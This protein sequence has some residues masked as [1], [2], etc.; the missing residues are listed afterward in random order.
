MLCVA[1]NSWVTL[2][3]DMKN[4]FED[5]KSF[6]SPWAERK[7]QLRDFLA[8][9]GNLHSKCGAFNAR[10]QI[11]GNFSALKMLFHLWFP[12]YASYFHGGTAVSRQTLIFLSHF[13]I[14]LPERPVS[15]GQLGEFL[16]RLCSQGM[17]LGPK[18]CGDWEGYVDA[19]PWNSWWAT[20]PTRKRAWPEV[21]GSLYVKRG[22]PWKPGHLVKSHWKSLKKFA[23]G[24]FTIIS[25]PIL[26][27][28]YWGLLPWTRRVVVPAAPAMLSLQLL[29]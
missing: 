10:P 24:V 4:L 19:P 2:G 18:I 9:Y 11:W 17:E 16:L 25:L 7:P 8:N 28:D 3:R 22:Q 15:A 14:L 1:A 13:F 5:D 21:C 26:P 6:P 23:P 27:R 12:F 20:C 29:F